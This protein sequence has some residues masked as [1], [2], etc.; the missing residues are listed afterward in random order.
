MEMK[1][2]NTARAL[3]A[4]VA[5]LAVS[6]TVAGAQGQ[7]REPPAPRGPLAADTPIAKGYNDAAKALADVDDNPVID[8]AY[9][10]WCVTGYGS[11]A[12]GET[13]EPLPPGPITDL[14]SPKGY[15]HTDKAQLMPPAGARFLDNAWY[16]GTDRT[17]AIVVKTDDGLVLLDALTTVEDV[18]EQLIGPMRRAG[19]DPA[20]IKYI[21]MGHGHGDHTGG[22]N[23]IRSKYAPGVQ[24]VM[25]QPDAAA[26][27]NQRERVLS[28][29]A[30]Q[31]PGASP[32]AP[33]SDAEK[34]RRLMGLPEKVDVQIAAHPDFR[35]GAR[36]IKMGSTELVAILN[37]GHTVGQ[38]TVIVPVKYKGRAHKMLVWS[39]N[40]SPQNAGLYGASAD[41]VRAVAY[42]EGADVF[43]NT[44][45]YQSAIF[46]HMRRQAAD[47]AYDNPMVLGV[48]GLQRY[49]GIFSNCQRA[50]V[51]RSKAGTWKRF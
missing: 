11:A 44:H 29:Q 28:G 51:E 1:H 43:A 34:Q 47:P 37:P 8:W 5:I 3:L 15:S 17:G 27:A 9:R 12:P 36:R 13:R 6:P 49:L 2:A 14:M 31:R 41:W 24:F 33:L 19:L 42:M 22:A 7:G 48:D 35:W 10:I 4:S 30:P 40:D 45:A 21:F 20:D 46:V 26:I 38:M 23:H 16:F 18:E 25:G 39:G 32:G 50:W